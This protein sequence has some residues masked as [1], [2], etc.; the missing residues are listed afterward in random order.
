[1]SGIRFHYT[2]FINFAAQLFS[3]ATGL[4]FVVTVTRNLS[5]ADFGTW[6]NIGDLLGYAT[7]LS[8]IVPFSVVRYAARG[9][10]DAIRTGIAANTLL[11]LPVTGIFALF[12]SFF[13]SLI[14]TNPLYFQFASLHVMM[15]YILPAVQNAV[16][17]KKP[18]ILGY[19]TVV[20]EFTKVSIGFFLV[21]Y[22]G[23]GLIGAIAAVVMAQVAMISF[24]LFSIREYLEERINWNYLRSWWKVS[25]IVIY[26]TIGNRLLSMGM[27]LLILTWGTAARAYVGA[28][29]TFAVIISY[30]TT[31]ATG[32]YSKL[33]AKPDSETVET[34]LKLMMLFAIPMFGGILVLSGQ[35]LTILRADYAAGAFVLYVYAGA[36][37]LDS[38]STTLDTIITAT[39]HA[40]MNNETTF[41]ELVKSKLFFLPTLTC[42]SGALYLSILLVFLKLFATEPIQAAMYTGLAYISATV[43]VFIIRYRTAKKSLPFS[44]P[45]R[46]LTRYIFAT[47]LMVV[48]LSQIKLGSTLTR[49]MIQAMIGSVIYF[50]I[51]L[52]IDSETRMLAKNIIDFMMKLLRNLYFYILRKHII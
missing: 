3:I 35:L 36:Y 11:S 9:H 1:M 18:H 38:L 48:F 41:R 6:Q 51:V 37:L 33:L 23:T 20:Y 4:F 27:I 2:G 25:F 24:Y 22:L 30:S 8:G 52:L 5:T 47:V 31:L 45:I 19:G 34:A 7:I 17:A 26:G 42:I 32:L 14:G 29:A 12:S 28:A 15:F 40:D 10:I 43:P 49:V 13:A 39:E 46:S 50:G 16:L 21:A 44:F